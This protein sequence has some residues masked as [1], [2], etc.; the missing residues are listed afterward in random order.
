MSRNNPIKHHRGPGKKISLSL[1][2]GLIIGAAT[3]YEY[4]RVYLPTPYITSLQASQATVCFTPG[5]K[6]L[7]LIQQAID[8]AKKQILVQ[9]YAFTAPVIADALIAA[10]KR[11][12]LV[13]ILVDR[14]QLT[15]KGSQ[16]EK[17][18]AYG[19]WVAIDQVPGIAHNKVMLIDDAY[20]LTGSFN[21]SNAAEYRNAENLLIIHNSELHSLYKKNWEK[22]AEQAIPLNA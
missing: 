4:A 1:I 9:A 16:V 18:K 14:S 7:P 10:H 6:C 19:I 3:G 11:G 21:W 2:I 8:Q 15:G 5:G 17:V 13:R 22:R 12:V 20:V